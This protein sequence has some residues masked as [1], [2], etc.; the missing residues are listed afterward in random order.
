MA[1]K[2]LNTVIDYNIL[3]SYISIFLI[4]SNLVV[5]TLKYMKTIAVQTI[6]IEKSQFTHIIHPEKL[7]ITSIIL[8]KKKN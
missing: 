7:N 1:K 2:S 3:F 6:T 4:I 8:T 5:E